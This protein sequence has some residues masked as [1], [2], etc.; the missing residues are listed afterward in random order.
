MVHHER[1]REVKMSVSYGLA[2]GLEFYSYTKRASVRNCWVF[3]FLKLN[4]A[5]IKM[6][7][8][9]LQKLLIYYK[10]LRTIKTCKLMITS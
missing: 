1:A 3:F 7:I 9:I 4:L 8:L 5:G 2:Y 10:L 6:Q